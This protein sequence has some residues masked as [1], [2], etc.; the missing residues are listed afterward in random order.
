MASSPKDMATPQ[1]MIVRY[2]TSRIRVPILLGNARTMRPCASAAITRR[3]SSFMHP[4]AKPPKEAGPSIVRKN[5]YHGEHKRPTHYYGGLHRVTL[6]HLGGHRPIP[7]QGDHTTRLA[8][9]STHDGGDP[10]QATHRCLYGPQIQSLGSL[11]HRRRHRMHRG[12]K[13]HP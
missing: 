5:I 13:P 1:R 9:A 10:P 12:A 6:P 2:A 8:R 7:D 4:F 3:V 11:C